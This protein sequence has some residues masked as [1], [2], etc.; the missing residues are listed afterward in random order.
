MASYDSWT[1]AD[2]EEATRTE[3]KRDTLQRDVSELEAHYTELLVKQKFLTAM[4]ELANPD[5]LPHD[6]DAITLAT[7]AAR[8]VKEQRKELEKK[9]KE[10]TANLFSQMSAMIAMHETL[11]THRSRLEGQLQQVKNQ[12]AEM[13]VLDDQTPS[14][15]EDS[16]QSKAA[17]LQSKFFPINSLIS[18]FSGV[19]ISQIS[20]NKVIFN[21]TVHGRQKTACYSLSVE[22]D[23]FK[24]CRIR[25][26]AISPDFPIADLLK[27][28]QEEDLQFLISETMTRVRNSLEIKAEVDDLSSV[29]PPGAF[30]W[31]GASSTPVPAFSDLVLQRSLETWTLRLSYDYPEVKE[32]MLIQVQPEGADGGK[33]YPTIT[34]ACTELFQLQR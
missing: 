18:A 23:P 32:V 19:E 8:Q 21:L 5:Q 7:R 26:A 9:T 4:R 2:V 29:L 11:N 24:D 15:T 17:P 3:Q 12:L 28:A 1:E 13:A 16:L 6:D 22:F 34:A 25:D 27:A 14:H 33:T 31:Q 30:H 20:D 10:N